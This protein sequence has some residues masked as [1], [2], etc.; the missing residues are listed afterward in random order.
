MKGLLSEGLGRCGLSLDLE[1]C[2]ALE[3][4]L[5]ELLRWNQRVNL[6]AIT[7]PEI[8]TEKHLIDSL[9]LL[10]FLVDTESLFDMGS[11]AG[12]PGIP[13]QIA[14]P[15]LAVTSVDSVGKKINFQRH[16]KRLLRLDPFTPIHSRLENVAKELPQGMR[17]DVVTARAFA[18][19]EAIIR[20]GASWR[21]P[22]GKIL[23]MKGP[24]G[25]T[26]AFAAEKNISEAG[27]MI[28]R[29]HKYTL[30]FSGAERQLIVLS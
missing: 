19:I 27:L 15:D 18:S 6:T 11:G 12:L 26:E 3:V 30:P 4:F 16:V 24:E 7:D 20:F 29:I 2:R 28:D 9:L 14:R 21:A 13:L 10:P 17:F 23:V 1:A 8:A 5:A 22:D 25:E